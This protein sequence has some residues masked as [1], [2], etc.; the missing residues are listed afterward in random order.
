MFS[1]GDSS[2]EGMNNRNKMH[3]FPLAAQSISTMGSNNIDWASLAQQWIQMKDFSDTMP[4]APP[5]PNISNVKEKS[6]EEQGEAD[7]EVEK[8]DEDEHQQQESLPMMII[9]HQHVPIENSWIIPQP[10]LQNPM[11]RLE[12]PFGKLCA[13]NG[14]IY[15]L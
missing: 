4:E 1:G 6:F 8:D 12:I 10:N 9:P 15:K 11:Q 5:P 7:M 2:E 3:S 13:L 14:E